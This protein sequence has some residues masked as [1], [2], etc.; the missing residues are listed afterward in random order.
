MTAPSYNKHKAG[1]DNLVTSLPS[2]LGP[3]ILSGFY[4]LKGHD[5]Q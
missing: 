3:Y 4:D 5:D 2:F 1:K